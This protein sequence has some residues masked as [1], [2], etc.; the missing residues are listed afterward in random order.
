MLFF[1]PL[2]LVTIALI[3]PY[4][5]T[6]CKTPSYLLTYALSQLPWYNHTGWLGVKQQVTYLLTYSLSQP[7]WYNCTGWLGVKH[8]VAYLLT[9]CHRFCRWSRKRWRPW[10][11]RTASSGA[12]RWPPC[13]T[14]SCTCTLAS[15]TSTTPSL[16]WSRWDSGH[17]QTGWELLAAGRQCRVCSL[18]AHHWPDQGEIQD[19]ARQV[20]SCLLLADSVECALQFRDLW[21]LW[22]WGHP[23]A[24]GP[25]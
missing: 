7:P 18:W 5:L 15:L 12:P 8:Q 3:Q 25:Q 10:R 11:E 22:E 4:L 6:G 19:T 16:T 13:C 17:S 14:T 1:V 24:V 23:L 21:Y 9:P 2:C 20:E